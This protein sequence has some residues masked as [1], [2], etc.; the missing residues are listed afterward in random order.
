M[1]IHL[2][3]ALASVILQMALAS[4]QETRPPDYSRVST[5]VLPAAADA[6]DNNM[7]VGPLLERPV[8]SCEGKASN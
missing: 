2:Y 7:P 5:P 4:A 8:T 6:A 1:R 3:L